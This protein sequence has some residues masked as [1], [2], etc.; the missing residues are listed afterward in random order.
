MP[1]AIEK[2]MEGIDTNN[3]EAVAVTIGPGQVMGLNI[4]LNLAMVS[5]LT[6][7]FVFIFLITGS[8]KTS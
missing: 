5:N 3:I 4:G 2:A 7:K 1:L 6:H 8:G